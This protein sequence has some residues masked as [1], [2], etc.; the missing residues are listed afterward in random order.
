MQPSDDE[1]WVPCLVSAA[2]VELWRKTFEE[3]PSVHIVGSA[4]DG[5]YYEVAMI[6]SFL[7]YMIDRDFSIRL[8]SELDEPHDVSLPTKREIAVHGIHNAPAKARKEYIRK[9]IDA[10]LVANHGRGLDRYYQDYAKPDILAAI[11]W[12][13]LTRDI[14]VCYCHSVLWQVTN[15]D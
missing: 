5:S 7:Q 4:F 13:F 10:T 14:L 8:P 6:R 12:G 2:D 1:V 11:C 3:L 15:R 9:A